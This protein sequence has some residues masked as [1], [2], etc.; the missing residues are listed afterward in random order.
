MFST[1]FSPDSINRLVSSSLLASR[2]DVEFVLSKSHLT[3][4]DLPIL[5]SP[6]AEHY[7]E[8][9][10]QKAHALTKQR[11]GN[12]MQLFIPMYVSNEC[13]NTCTYCGFSVEHK[14]VRKTLTDEEIRQEAA[15]LKNKGF[16]HVL[17]LTGE[18]PK[19]V[20]TDYIANAVRLL[21][22]DFASVGIE[23]Q[24]MSV[25]DYHVVIQAGADSLTLYQETYHPDSYA[26]H[27]L[28]GMKKNYLNR[29]DAPDRGAK[30]GF[31]RINLGALLGLYD[32]RFD[33]L[34][35]AFH[36]TYLQKYY[37]KTKYA[38]SFPRINDVLGGYKPTYSVSDLS[39]VQ[40]ITS[41]RLVYPDIGITLS[42]REPASLRDQLI[43]L[44]ITTM[45]A[46]SNTSPGGY[47][48]NEFE[49]Q[50]EISDERSVESIKQL[51]R[52][53][54]YEPVQKDWD[55]VFCANT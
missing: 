51:L 17:L 2:K 54:G 50:F 37:W 6:A 42:T 16:Q 53:K 3:F 39:L 30:A 31:Y 8:I 11:F 43:P 36:V 21:A 22:A 9:M 52:S 49:K 45:S 47:T 12:T 18:S 23:V 25:D 7:I 4:E 34:S 38:V 29:L 33:A 28:A 32:W 14:Y 5:L 40:L 1:F 20:G 27:H 55:S 10:A 19:N 48:Q 15:F 46:E 13:F 41:F 26:K 24:P 44:G 35:M